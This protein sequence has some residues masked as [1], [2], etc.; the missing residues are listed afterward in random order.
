MSRSLY[1]LVLAA[2][3]ACA[4][5]PQAMADKSLR[6]TEAGDARFPERSFVLGAPAGATFAPGQ[7]DVLE[8]GRR[9]S[10]LEVVSAKAAGSKQLGLVLLIDASGS[11][12]GRPI[13]AAMRAA[14]TLARHRNPQ[15]PLAIVT[16]GRKS[17]LLLPFTTDERKIRRALSAPPRARRGTHIYDA[18]SRAV[19]LIE[20]QGVS[21]GSM[22]LLSD[23]EDSGS[24]ASVGG[25]AAR[26]RTAGA[27]VFTVGLE[28]PS[29][30]PKGLRRLATMT[31]ARYFTA[32]QPGDLAAI[33]DQLG[34]QLSSEYLLR[35]RS[36]AGP[37]LEAVVE[38]RVKGIAGT[39]RTSYLTPS[40]RAPAA[41]PQK[42]SFG[43]GFW[44][45]TLALVLVS[46]VCALPLAVVG[47]AVARNR[48]RTLRARL[49]DFVSMPQDGPE[50]G[51][52]T[53]LQGQ[54][55]TGA[56]K[57]LEKRLWWVRF[58][59]EVEIARL[60]TPAIQVVAATAVGTLTA[61]FMLYLL[62]GSALIAVLGLGVPVAVRAVLK[63]KLEQQR[64]LFAEQLGENCEILASAMRAGHSLVGAL[65]VLID[66]AAEPSRTEFS[67]VAADE[68]LGVPL[69]AALAVVARRMASKDLPQVAIVAALQRDTGGSTA[70]VLD[71]VA[72][73]IRAR[74]A[75][76]RM[77]ATL[78]AQGR[79]SRW[80]VTALPV[81]L[82][83]AIA[84]LNP[85]YLKP[86]F[87][88]GMGHVLIVVGVVMVTMGS[89]VIKRIVDIKA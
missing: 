16:F 68:R 22:V 67:R 52:A 88:T 75:L 46:L 73:G 35:Y 13:R 48:K 8:N 12:K 41:A 3:L 37:G 25:A 64:K 70:E 82:L 1:G 56:E 27:R 7:I 86:L 74:F 65:S 63:R 33:Y 11:M 81:V 85:G 50:S 32:R 43:E 28:S 40:H 24:R 66:E 87:T 77:I 34:A 62:S 21:V 39:A 31:H 4:L 71:R 53:D 20:R 60:D 79:M 84:V 49:A 69:E 29:L 9:V 23:G 47:V 36:K 89:L 5:A 17:S 14:R 42:D 59:E 55:L 58:K 51:S 76:R 18:L 78:T 10:G 44:S 61:I 38:A 72:E 26:A 6:L 30:D 45:S 80:V 57:S 83:L 15:Q 19:T 54:M 2:I